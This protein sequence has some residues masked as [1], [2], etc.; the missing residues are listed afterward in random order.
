MLT[1]EEYAVLRDAKN[2]KDSDVAKMTGITPVTFSSW[3][4]GKYQP[5]HNKIIKILE[6]VGDISLKY[7]RTYDY[8]YDLL[9]QDA[10]EQEAKKHI[11]LSREETALLDKFNLMNK[12]GKKELTDYADYILS[13]PKYRGGLESDASSDVS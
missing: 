11:T 12:A 2:L 10:A 7:E 9:L 1:Y 5:K 3:K 13:K 6:V 8:D 4:H